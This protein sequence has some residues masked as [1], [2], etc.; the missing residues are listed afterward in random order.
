MWDG[1]L[2]VMDVG[3]RLRQQEGH[4]LTTDAI[5]ANQLSEEGKQ[6]SHS[7]V[8]NRGDAEEHGLQDGL[9]LW[10]DTLC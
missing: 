8:S 6:E 5:A 10:V 4:L 7:G 2:G 3:E 9:Q 1:L